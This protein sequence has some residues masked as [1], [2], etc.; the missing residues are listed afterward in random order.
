MISLKIRR[1]SEKPDASRTA[2]SRSE[3][4]DTTIQKVRVSR[5]L[6][7]FALLD[8]RE[9]RPA[10]LA[11]IKTG[12]IYVDLSRITEEEFNAAVARLAEARG[13]I[14]DLRGY[15]RAVTPE[16]IG[17]LIDQPVTCAQWLIPVTYSPDRRDVGFSMSNWTFQPK[18]PRFHGKVGF[19][20]DG[21]AIRYAETYL[22]IIEHYKLAAIVSSPTAG[23]NGNVNPFSLPGGIQ[24]AWT[25]MKVLKHDGSRH[26]G[27]GI[28]PTVPA[29]RTIRG[30]TEGRDEVLDRA[31]AVVSP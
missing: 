28:R 27:V 16:T 5:C 21:R 31:I 26:H 4:P 9:P 25:G 8:L 14:F 11:S 17:H 3:G 15:P 10:K 24:V 19:L 12:V 29:T 6:D 30:V 23:T 7:M 13:M 2:D 22:G 20:T 18:A 1:P